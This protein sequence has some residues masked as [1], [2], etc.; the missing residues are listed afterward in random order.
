MKKSCPASLVWAFAALSILFF[1]ACP[2][3][4]EDLT[5]NVAWEDLVGK[6]LILQA[7][8]TGNDGG[9][10]INRSF[11]E[12]YN[13]SDKPVNLAGFS[14]WFANGTRPVNAGETPAERDEDWAQI[15]LSGTIPA[16]GSFLVLGP[17]KTDP[18]SPPRFSIDYPGDFSISALVLGN[19]SFKAAL[20]Y[21]TTQLHV[22]IQNPFNID[23]NG[24]KINGYIDM[25]GSWNDP[26]H[27]RP[28]Q[29]LGFET[30]PARNSG[31]VAIRRKNLTD[32]D[33]NFVDFESIRYA[34]S[35]GSTPSAIPE[36]AK[37]ELWDFYKPKTIACGPWDPMDKPD[38]QPPQ[39]EGLMILQVYGIGDI[40]PDDTA[41]THS[42]IEL[43]NNSDTAIDLSGFSV[44]YADGINRDKRT[45][46][47]W[48]KINLTGSIP[49]R[50]SYLILGKQMRQ[51]NEVAGLI[52]R[53]NLINVTP[54][55]HITTFTLSNRSWQ[56]ALMS[57]QNNLTEPD[58]WGKTPG[59][60]DI[61]SAN[62]DTSNE[63]DQVGAAKGADDL[64]AVNNA[65]AGSGSGARTIS[66]Q[67]SMRR[68]SLNVT[69]VTLT[70]FTSRQYTT[71][72]IEDITRFRPRTTAAGSWTPEF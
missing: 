70:D 5:S 60:I 6:L 23:G 54:D 14:L 33:N 51:E 13:N 58:P 71:L 17:E 26:D 25:V 66:K 3:G 21:G 27:N 35:S 53:L 50:G 56:V 42:F 9:A 67:K 38:L 68:T 4:E 63:R 59:C 28:D 47:P 36:W 52:G 61:V 34:A 11:V 32:T 15:E 18:A 48:T 16:K 20:I 65:S 7:Y 57:N 22:D 30:S 12:L 64:A 2:N 41:G 44:H 43:Y 55:L 45:V 31:S 72:S 49:A 19:R 37:D 8:G 1:S 29:I 62:N 46:D 69:N 39:T 40:E 24:K 10:G